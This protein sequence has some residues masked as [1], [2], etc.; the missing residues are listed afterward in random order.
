MNKESRGYAIILYLIW[1]FSAL[2]IGIRNIDSPFGRRLIIAL[3]AFLGF[4]AY[5]FG[6]LQRYE[7]DF[8]ALQTA[9]LEDVFTT[10]I[11]LQ[12]GKLYNSFVS[13]ITGAVFESHHYYFLIM[14]AVYGYYYV[15]TIN[16][17]KNIQLKKLDIFGLIFFSGLFLFLFVRAIPNLAF[18]TGGVFIMYCMVA[19]FRK[20]EKMYLYL[21]LLAPLFH[22]GLFIYILLPVLLL[23]FRNKVWYYIVFVIITFAVGKS[24]VVG[25]IES[26]A[27]SNSDTI[28]ESKYKAYAS[29]RGQ[30]SL[31]ERYATNAANNN[32]KLQSLVYLQDLIW[33]YF[34]PFGM[35][36][37]LLKRKYLLVDIESNLLFHIVLLFWGVS[38]LMQNISQ[39]L[40]FLVLFCFLAIGFFFVIYIKTL[41]TPKK[42]FFHKFLFVFV[43]ILFLYGIMGTYA[44]NPIFSAQFFISNFFIE[45]FNHS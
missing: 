25:V 43:P 14:F 24:S 22:I 33:Y 23:I 41:D 2:L 29:E 16:L 27:A 35:L 34:V 45:I 7:I 40:R 9:T 31:D 13:L 19:Y 42:T 15:N 26:L 6:D 37:A 32:L 21:I 10:F 36:I 20:K 11:S 30:E 17:L 1:P 3:Y 8:Y 18:Y 4:T 39:G 38:N 5:S 28:I 44:S 12:D